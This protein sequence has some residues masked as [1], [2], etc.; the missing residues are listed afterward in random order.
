MEAAPMNRVTTLPSAREQ[1]RHALLLLGAPASA[2][3][4]VATHQ[5]LFDGDLDMPGL[6]TLLRAERRAPAPTVCR[7]L[8]AALAPMHVALAEWPLDH[9][10]VTPVT[11][12]A[13]TL[14][15]VIRI[16]EFVAMQPGAARSAE[17]L[18]RSL[19]TEVPGGPEAFDLA[20]AAREAIVA[21]DVSVEAA[22]REAIAVR[23][24][25]L[26][27]AHRLF[28]VPPVPRQRDGV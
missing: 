13:A 6:A 5:A 16:S 15:A 8:S 24:A 7:G 17:R 12:R 14:T 23:A 9:R 10:I 20:A 2:R 3:L 11:A 26:D 22:L 18:L 25:A 4:V 28:G 19:A 27:P 21:T 1:A